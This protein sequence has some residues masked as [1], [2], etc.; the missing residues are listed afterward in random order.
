VPNGTVRAW[1]TSV[2]EEPIPEYTVRLVE[3]ERP[4][5]DLPIVGFD[6]ECAECGNTVT[7]EGTTASI[8]EQRHHFCCESCEERFVQQYEDLAEGA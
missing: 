8:D 4:G 7:N 5:D 1:V 6:V 3:D 2:L